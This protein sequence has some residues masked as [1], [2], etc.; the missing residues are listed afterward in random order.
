[1][2]SIEKRTNK[3]KVVNCSYI[4]PTKCRSETVDAEKK[5]RLNWTSPRF[6]ISQF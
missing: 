1:M 2:I 3:N 4:L 5:K 6:I